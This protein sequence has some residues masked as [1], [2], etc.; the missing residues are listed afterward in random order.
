MP[1]LP[2]KLFSSH[3]LSERCFCPWLKEYS[4]LLH[5]SRILHSMHGINSKENILIIQR[6]IYI[7]KVT[8]IR[9][10]NT[11]KPH[12]V[13]SIK[14]LLYI[15]YRHTRKSAIGTDWLHDHHNSQATLPTGYLWNFLPW[16]CGVKSFPA[17]SRNP[18]RTIISYSA[19]GAVVFSTSLL[20]LRHYVWSSGGSALLHLQ[21]LLPFPT[22][23]QHTARR[24]KRTSP[25]W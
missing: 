16:T 25:L 2:V 7:L 19:K 18:D 24:L 9:N 20:R 10:F 11:L 8:K 4:F 12:I 15:P 1:V 3:I 21:E 22:D 13:S 5:T 17:Y 6:N 23:F 14:P